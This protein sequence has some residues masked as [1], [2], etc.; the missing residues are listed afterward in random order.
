M[1]H[2]VITSPKHNTLNELLHNKLTCKIFQEYSHSCF[3][4]YECVSKIFKCL[5]TI[6]DASQYHK[7]ILK[8]EK[9]PENLFLPIHC[10]ET[11]VQYFLKSGNFLKIGIS[12]YAYY[13]WSFTI[14]MQSL[15]KII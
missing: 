13:Q 12:D 2:K 10:T 7:Q 5:I 6:R 3:A 15:I 14:F 1:V 11:S 8:S 9:I 4:I